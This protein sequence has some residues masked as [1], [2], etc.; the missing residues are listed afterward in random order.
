MWFHPFIWCAIINAISYFVWKLSLKNKYEDKKQCVSM[1]F[2]FFHFEKTKMK[3]NVFQ[4]NLY[5][6]L[7]TVETMLFNANW[8]TNGKCMYIS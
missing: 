6:L 7:N 3:C 1:Q 8:S 5:G 4:C 2:F